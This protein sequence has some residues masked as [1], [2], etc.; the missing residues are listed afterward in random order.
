M[1]KLNDKQLKFC[2]LVLDGMKHFKAY[3][4]VYKADNDATARTNSSK[5]LIKANIIEYMETQRQKLED[6]NLMS[7]HYKRV[8]L[9]QIVDN[10][11]N[12]TAIIAAIK[13]DNE[14]TGDNAP[15][16]TQEINNSH[17]NIKVIVNSIEE[18]AEIMEMLNK[19]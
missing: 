17:D 12:D 1:K 2:N 13:L 19:A 16:K 8:K 15:I 10:A 14:M 9:K 7:R 5:L 3:Q 4:E 6:A 11:D 18:Q